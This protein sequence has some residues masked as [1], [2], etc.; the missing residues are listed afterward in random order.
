MLGAANADLPWPEGD[1]IE[2]LWHAATILR[3]HR[4]DGHVADLLVAGLDGPESL[5]WRAALGG[6]RAFLQPARGWTDEEWAAA[7]SRLTDRGWLTASGAATDAARAAYEEA[8]AVTDRLA[9][10]PWERLGAAG[11]ERCAELLRPIAIRAG[12]QLPAAT[13]LLLA[14]IDE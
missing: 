12:K 8:E 2:V 6:E 4:G 5:V 7:A 10:E 11:T 13:P 3:E 14:P 1:P 9:G